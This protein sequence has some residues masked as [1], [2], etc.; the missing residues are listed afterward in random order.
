MQGGRC[1]RG[2][3]WGVQKQIP[4]TGTNNCNVKIV[5][6]EQCTAVRLDAFCCK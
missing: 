3:G 5:N 4:F 1:I 2:M 6:L